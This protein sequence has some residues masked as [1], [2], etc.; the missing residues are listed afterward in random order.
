MS[1]NYIQYAGGYNKDNINLIDIE[2]AII[3]IQHADDEHCAFWFSVITKD[4][5]VIET[6]KYLNLA[7][8]F[9]ENQINYKARDWNEVKDL[10]QLLLEEKF[11]T[12]QQRIK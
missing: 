1:E 5:N 12:I 3:E 6:D 8:I 10:Y 2:K 7:I 11:E 4:E 9:E